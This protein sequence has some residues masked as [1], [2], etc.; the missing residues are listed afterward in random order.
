MKFKVLTAPTS[1]IISPSG[2]VDAVLK[3]DQ[4]NRV[5]KTSKK[6]ISTKWILHN[7]EKIN[8]KITKASFLIQLPVN[9][10]L[11]AVFKETAKKK[12]LSF[13]ARNGASVWPGYSF[14]PILL[15]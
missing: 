14:N 15:G 5:I 8:R 1:S 6:L 2:N 4:A 12:Y 7:Y 9:Y 3:E 11:K 10:Q 13:Y